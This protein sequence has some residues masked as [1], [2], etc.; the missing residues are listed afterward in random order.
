MEKIKLIDIHT[1]IIPNVDD[2]SS[3]TKESIEML[4]AFIEQGV[5][6]VIITPHVN[7]NATTASWKTQ[8][9][10]YKALKQ[11]IK[12]LNINTYLG[13]ELRYRA[14]LDMEYEKYKIENTNYILLEFSWFTEDPVYEIIEEVQS[15]GL[16]PI[17][18]HVERYSY[19]EHN[20]YFKLKEMGVLLQVN[21][22][23]IIGTDRESWRDNASFLIKEKLVDFIASDAHNMGR[24]PPNIKEAYDVLKFRVDK[25]YLED[26]FYNNAKKI[27]DSNNK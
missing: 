16:I 6:D 26:I 9:E 20:D 25:D 17:I 19:L 3:S 27:I 13:A 18:A 10:K 15:F 12:D 24:R 23:A 14:H 5:T 22:G 1:H 4:K 11:Q 7:S 2:G 21:T 8:K